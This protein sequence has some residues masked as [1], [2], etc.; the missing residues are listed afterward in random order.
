M[1]IHIK[2]NL[3]YNVISMFTSNKKSNKFLEDKYY[4]N[5][6][7]RYFSFYIENKFFEAGKC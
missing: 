1:Y 7:V 5:E 2:S 6:K 4:P 3:I